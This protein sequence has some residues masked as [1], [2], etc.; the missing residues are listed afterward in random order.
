MKKS[1]LLSALGMCLMLLLT[2]CM[3]SVTQSNETEVTTEI[4][5]YDKAAELTPR[6][7]MEL[8]D[9]Y[10]KLNTHMKKHLGVG[11]DREELKKATKTFE[12]M[13][14]SNFTWAFKNELEKQLYNGVTPPFTKEENVILRNPEYQAPGNLIRLAAMTPVTKDDDVKLTYNDN[15]YMAAGAPVAVTFE[16]GLVND[17]L[18]EWNEMKNKLKTGE[19]TPNEYF[20]W[21][22]TWPHA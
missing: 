19:I 2:S 6:E 17:F 22:I 7:V 5:K 20:E 8:M 14:L 3:F 4:G 15:E 11:E 21:K 18:L 1:A 16:Y 9:S 13:L 10:T 12:N